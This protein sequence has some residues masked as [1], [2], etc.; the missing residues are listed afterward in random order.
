MI[1]ITNGQET[2]NVT[3]GAYE[4]IYKAMG[5][6]I[7]GDPVIESAGVTLEQDEVAP[8]TDAEASDEATEPELSEDEKWAQEVRKKPISQWSKQE[9]KRYAD[10]MD[11]D[12]TGVESVRAVRSRI[13]ASWE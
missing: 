11:I 1:D 2:Y 8:A 12:L 13:S 5:F 9:L 3:R 10:V 4:S 6:H 7:V